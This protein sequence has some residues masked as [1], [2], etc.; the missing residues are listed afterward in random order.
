MK[1]FFKF[2]EIINKYSYLGEVIKGN[3]I[4]LIG[5]APHIA[6]KAYLHIIF[7]PL[8]E[9][10]IKDL[11]KELNETIPEDYKEFL[12]MSNGLIYF[13]GTLALYGKRLNYIRNEDNVWQ[14]F[15][16]ITKNIYERPRGSK[17]SYFYIGSYSYDGSL[18]YIDKKNNRTY[19]CNR[20]IATPL[21]EWN[22]FNE[23]LF[24]EVKRISL[25]FNEKGEKRK[26]IP[27]TPGTN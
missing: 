10:E 8:S 17:D 19:R 2:K 22:S 25:L 24:I 15:S 1:S 9:K 23:M 18:L 5:H 4:H 27:T 14:P 11:E 7:N 6:P 3:G 21:N 12:K 13:N 16:I 20:R 26:E